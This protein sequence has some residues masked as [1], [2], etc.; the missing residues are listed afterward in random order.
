MAALQWRTWMTAAADQRHLLVDAARFAGPEL[1]VAGAAN[2]VALGLVDVDGH[3]AEGAAPF[4]HGR[5]VVRVRNRDRRQAADRP[6][7]LD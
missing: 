1:H 6:Q 3:V 4:H 7:R 5:V 2:P